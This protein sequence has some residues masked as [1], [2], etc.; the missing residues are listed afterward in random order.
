MAPVRDCPKPLHLVRFNPDP[1]TV[2]GR[3]HKMF[4]S[5]RMELLLEVINANVWGVSYICCD[6]ALK[7]TVPLAI[8][9]ILALALRSS[10]GPSRL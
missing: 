8:I 1:F 10:A 2:N 7:L 5:Q 4:W 9:L 6:N 3:R